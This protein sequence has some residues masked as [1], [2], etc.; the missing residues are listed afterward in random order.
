MVVMKFFDGE[1]PTGTLSGG[2]YRHVLYA[3][4]L[5]PPRAEYINKRRKA[6]LI[7]VERPGKGGT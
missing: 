4:E 6:V 3:L 5:L 7:D 2:L 1:S